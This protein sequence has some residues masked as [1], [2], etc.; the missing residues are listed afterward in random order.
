MRSP[1]EGPTASRFS[2]RR[3]RG[4]RKFVAASL[5]IDIL[6]RAGFREEIPFQ[7]SAVHTTGYHFVVSSPEEG[8]TGGRG[9]LARG[10][11]WPQGEALAPVA[12]P[13]ATP[14]TLAHRSS[15]VL[16]ASSTITAGPA[17]RRA[18]LRQAPGVPQTVELCTARRQTR[19]TPGSPPLPPRGLRD[20]QR[21]RQPGRTDEGA[22]AQISAMGSTACARRMH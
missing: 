11:Y 22:A 16:R 18:L 17:C 10:A 19:P 9:L 1:Y 8:P 14:L 2:L 20:G 5:A 7:A 12:S 3:P 21:A 13:L 6:S 4:P 15:L